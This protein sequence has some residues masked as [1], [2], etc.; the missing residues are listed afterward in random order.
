MRASEAGVP[1]L[2][3]VIAADKLI[4]PIA[5]A[6][7]SRTHTTVFSPVQLKAITKTQQGFTLTLEGENTSTLKT[8]ML[9]AADGAKSKVREL[10]QVPVK[11]Q[12]Y[13][14]T[15]IVSDITISKPH[16]ETAYERFTKQ[17]PLALLPLQGRRCGLVWAVPDAYLAEVKALSDAAF[18]KALQKNFGHRL[19]VL[20]AASERVSFPLALSVTEDIADAGLFF[21]GNAAQSLHPI[22]AQGFNLGLRDVAMLAQVIRDAVQ[23]QCPLNA[24]RL[25][26]AYREK[27]QKDRRETIRLTDFL[28]RVFQYDFAPLSL[29]R[30]LGLC[31]VDRIS[32]LKNVLMQH[33]LGLAGQASELASGIALTD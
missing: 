1:A 24:M 25:A 9:V 27:R 26:K 18:L 14:Q 17:G 10:R 28:P 12:A 19:G 29:A 3:Y 32:P 4:A 8:T 5:D 30:D 11:R 15:A 13:G 2:G 7:R 20:N 31:A 6:V 21:I 23:T 16:A 22:A 33:S